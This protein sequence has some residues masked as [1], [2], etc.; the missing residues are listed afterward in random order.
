[1]QDA[2]TRSFS[3][4]QL[5][6]FD[7]KEI[8][9]GEDFTWKGDIKT[10]IAKI[11]KETVELTEILLN[12]VAVEQRKINTAVLDVNM[13]ECHTQ[14][15]IHL[16][17]REIPDPKCLG[18][19][20]DEDKERLIHQ[21]QKYS[22]KIDTLRK[23][24]EE[25]AGGFLPRK[26]LQYMLVKANVIKELE[27]LEKVLASL[28]ANPAPSDELM[29]TVTMNKTDSV[30]ARLI[31]ALRTLV[32]LL[33]PT[34]VFAADLGASLKDFDWISKR[35]WR[36]TY[37]LDKRFLDFIRDGKLTITSTLLC[38]LATPASA[39]HKITAQ[40]Y[41]DRL[42]ALRKG[43]LR[44]EAAVKCILEENAVDAYSRHEEMKDDS[45]WRNMLA[46]LKTLQTRPK[47]LYVGCEKPMLGILGGYMYAASCVLLLTE[48]TDEKQEILLE[49]KSE[50]APT[51]QVE[52]FFKHGLTATTKL[53]LQAHARERNRKEFEENIPATKLWLLYANRRN[54]K[55]KLYELPESW[56]IPVNVLDSLL[57]NLF[58]GI[59]DVADATNLPTVPR[60]FLNAVW[61]FES[62]R[63]LKYSEVLRVDT[64]ANA[65]RLRRYM[66]NGTSKD[67]NGKNIVTFRG[68]LYDQRE[69]TFCKLYDGLLPAILHPKALKACQISL[70][71]GDTQMMLG[72]TM[73][74][75][76]VNSANTVRV[77][78]ANSICLTKNWK[79]QS[80]WELL[81]SPLFMTTYLR[82]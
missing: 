28:Q 21:A 65:N 17:S 19:L 74:K 4:I 18:K 73:L 1:M 14:K 9:E 41:L 30:S 5:L 42:N 6:T 24:A 62:D 67:S 26:E 71:D 36:S 3:Y 50:D 70:T 13:A 63:F 47:P 22:W 31:K 34:F 52:K 49:L 46:F 8:V 35:D 76:V 68:F 53:N 57:K 33:D 48:S 78:V 10:L 72:L 69:Y 82:H 66:V 75:Q 77:A 54:S 15:N 38:D 55:A 44:H 43:K 7:K 20:S 58:N 56:R 45:A 79:K 61:T 29:E 27:E 59:F 25:K 40:P 64:V 23:Y 60:L 2:T 12:F 81:L 51:K 80:Y 11:K 39:K 32:A 16:V 37:N